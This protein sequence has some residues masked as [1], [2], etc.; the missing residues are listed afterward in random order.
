MMEAVDAIPGAPVAIQQVGVSNFKIPLG[1]RA[2][3]GRTVHT[4]ETAVTGT[5]SLEAKLKGINMS[6]IV[7]S[8]YDHAAEPPP[9]RSSRRSSRSTAGTSAPSPPASASISP[10]R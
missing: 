2:R 9:P 10:T 5:V 1:Y 8:F 4:L 7:R 6:R 3:S